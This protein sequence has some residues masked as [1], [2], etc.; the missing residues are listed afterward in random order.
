MK[1]ITGAVYFLY[2]GDELVYIGQSN[3]VFGRIGE[4]IR[5]KAKTFTDFRIY[6]TEDYIRLES[7][8]IAALRPKYNKTNGDQFD[9]SYSERDAFSRQL[10]PEKILELIKKHEQMHPRKYLKDVANNHPYLTKQRVCQLLLHHMDEIPIYRVDHEWFIDVD[11][12][13][14]NEKRL[15]RLISVW[16]NEDISER[17]KENAKQDH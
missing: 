2:D 11:W 16:D 3:N 15:I 6:E 12:Y 7:F 10:P 5:E 9:W 13:T 17:D 14:E 4:H 1:P 8:L